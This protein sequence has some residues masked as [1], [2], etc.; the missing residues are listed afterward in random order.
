MRLHQLAGS[1][2]L[3]YDGPNLSRVEDLLL[4]P[5]VPFDTSGPA[6]QHPP[7]VPPTAVWV[8]AE[9]E[10]QFSDTDD[11]GVLHGPFRSWRA[12]GTLRTIA[13]HTHG[14]QVG[15]AWRFHP[16]GSLFS[17]GQFVDGSPWGVHR[18]YANSDL[19]AERLQSCCVPQGAWQ[20]RQEH[21][22][23]GLVDRAWF[24]RDGVRL[25]ENG[26][27]Y[28]DRPSA[29]LPTA[30]FNENT[31]VW[32]AGVIR[33][34][35]G[36]TGTRRVWSSDGV[37]LMVEDLNHGKRHGAVQSF[38]EAGVLRWEGRYADGRRS[39]GFR[40]RGHAT[41]HFM[42]GSVHEQE[43]S[44]LDDQAVD[45]WRTRD[46]GGAVLAE[47]DLGLAL[48]E[49]ALPLS[50]VLADEQRTAA[51]WRQLAGSLFDQRRVAEGLLAGARAAATSGDPGPFRNALDTMTIP[52]GADAARA[53]ANDVVARAPDQLIPLLDA[54]KRGADAAILLCAIGKALVSAEHA[55]LDF[56]TTALL[57][58]PDWTEPLATRALVFGTRGDLVLARAD[59]ARLS[60][61]APEEATTLELVLR[62]YFP[63]FD[64]WPAQHSFQ[65]R[66]GEAELQPAR[67]PSE[68][69][70]VV[71]R[72][73]TRLGRLREA[74][75]ARVAD[76][77]PFMIPDL[78]ALLPT[79]PVPLARFA[80]TMSQDEYAGAD[81]LPEAE[82]EA[83]AGA[84]ADD[85]GDTAPASNAAT[86]E[87][88]EIA[89]DETQGLPAGAT[90]L[91]PILPILPILRQARA[92][93]SALTWLCWAVGLDAP[94]LPDE[95]RPPPAFGSAAMMTMERTW[96]CR[97]K[98]NTSG[99]LA[100]TKGIP[101]FDWEGTPID[102]VPATLA[103]VA[104]GEYLE[105]R[106]VFS[107]LCDPANRSPW[108]DDL[109]GAD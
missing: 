7:G 39:G 92:D 35:A 94:G 81:P 10:W 67:T 95:I 55:T 46:A 29:V 18:R 64:F 47:R 58:R 63:R 107:W 15:P 32:E 54:L 69:S 78:S 31:G 97:D 27:L 23:S 80:F 6:D 59:I 37:L 102:L 45:I 100:L 52:L 85:T 101:G 42:D 91:M 38:D 25:L 16:D 41:D 88:I 70:E 106:A 89:V 87:A 104:L 14:K 53:E 34:E 76:D 49:N 22:S 44:F 5:P 30:W 90:T 109:R 57:L 36:R 56:L 50:P 96:R 103:E 11:A 62:A 84:G 71:M 65:A 4:T 19:R 60:V 8:E 75:R 83:E 40:A 108:Q 99:L 77:A 21:G 51:T 74:L 73:A 26:D 98:L 86:P 61:G 20:L 13:A 17:L 68:V 48:D 1:W 43:G 24:N 28:P 93:W 3:R 82:A 79:G 66:A 9:Q 2:H 105:A 33:E 72:Y 12:D